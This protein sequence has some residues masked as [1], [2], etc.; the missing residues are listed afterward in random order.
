MQSAALYADSVLQSSSLFFSYDYTDYGR[1][2][3]P[4]NTYNSNNSPQNPDPTSYS[5]ELIFFQPSRIS[6]ASYPHGLSG[7]YSKSSMYISQQFIDSFSEGDHRGLVLE[8][9]QEATL[10][11]IKK[12]TSVNNAGKYTTMKYSNNQGFNDV[13][14]IRLSEVKLNK[15][16]ALARATNSIHPEALSHLNDIR[17][18]PFA[19]D[20]KPAMLTSAD[21][22]SVDEFIFEILDQRN[23]ELAFEG[24][25]RWDIVRTDRL[26]KDE[27]VARNRMTLPVPTYEIRIS[28]GAI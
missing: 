17:R 6:T 21:F 19:T 14:Y 24:H 23:K 28:Y 22:N 13:I 25:S 3:F 1:N 9:N 27:S 15:A 20:K 18:K 26:L 7:L 8:D 4:D 10:C 16:E 2:I 11:L 5:D 12:G